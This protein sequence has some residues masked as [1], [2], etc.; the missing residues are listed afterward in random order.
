MN[1]LINLCARGG[2]KGVKNKNTREFMGNCLIKYTLAAA[3]LFKEECTDYVDICVNSDSCTILDL[4]SPYDL[5]LIKR[6]VELATDSAPKIPA[7]RYSLTY[8]EK[9]LG[10]KYEYIIDL[11]ITSPFRNKE[12]IENVLNIMRVN[13]SLD[14]VFSVVKSRRNPYFNMVEKKCGEVKK[15]IG[16]CFETRQQAPDVYDMNASIYCYRRESLL[17]KLKTSPQKRIDLL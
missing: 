7:I 13:P 3:L 1:I 11:D 2:S 10:K 6:P 15:I 4:M 9:C 8:M 14:T 17:N 12:D 5:T 16:S